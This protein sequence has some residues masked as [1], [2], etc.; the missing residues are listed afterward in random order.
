M[1]IVVTNALYIPGLSTFFL[2]L[3]FLCLH[4]A[5]V[6]W[7][8]VFSIP[9]QF[10]SLQRNKKKHCKIATACTHTLCICSNVGLKCILGAGVPRPR[11]THAWK[12]SAALSVY[13]KKRAKK[14]AQRMKR[15]HKLKTDE[16]VEEQ[17]NIIKKSCTRLHWK[18]FLCCERSVD[19]RREKSAGT[20]R[21]TTTDGGELVAYTAASRDQR[22][23]ADRE[24][25]KKWNRKKTHSREFCY[26]GALGGFYTR[27]FTYT[28]IGGRPTAEVKE[29]CH[30]ESLKMNNTQQSA[31]AKKKGKLSWVQCGWALVCIL[32]DF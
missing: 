2:L 8:L 24:N 3:F 20:S 27:C 6:N 14:P 13:A 31:N 26:D 16:R 15:L 28:Y 32:V 17:A 10:L 30:G 5:T 4:H 21:L 7:I 25:G 11:A 9:Q 22:A 23:A 19:M 12:L 18:G 1:L 29:L